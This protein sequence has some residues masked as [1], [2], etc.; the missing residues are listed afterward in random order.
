MRSWSRHNLYELSVSRPGRFI[1]GEKSR[2]Y[3][4][5]LRLNRRNLSCSYQESKTDSPVVYTLYRLMF[6]GSSVQR[7]LKLYE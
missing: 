7:V 3:P 5:G 4:L 1:P 2:L 6:I